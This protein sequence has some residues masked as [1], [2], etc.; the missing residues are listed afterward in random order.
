MV[1]SGDFAMSEADSEERRVLH[2]K[3]SKHGCAGFDQVGNRIVGD[4]K[5]I[6]GR[7][8]PVERPSTQGDEEG[9]FGAEDAVHGSHG[10]AD[11][12]GHPANGKRRHPLGF[13]DPFGGVEERYRSPL[14]VLSG[15]SHD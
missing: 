13:D 2:G 15:A 12:G 9:G 1:S 14:V 6:H 4:G 3:A 7:R 5:G 10:G 11:F 8:K